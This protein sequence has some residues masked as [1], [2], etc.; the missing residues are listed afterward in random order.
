MNYLRAVILV[1]EDCPAKE[2]VIPALRNG[3]PTVAAIQYALLADHP[4]RYTQ[5]DIL[6]ETYLTQ[7]EL[8]PG[9]RE[10]AVLRAEFFSKERPC[11]KNMA[12]VFSSMSREKTGWWV[13]VHRNIKKRSRTGGSK[14]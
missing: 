5:E 13:W 1:A 3:K 9:E 2:P 10:K 11:L 8:R 12:G 14:N 6:F 4:Y 7:N